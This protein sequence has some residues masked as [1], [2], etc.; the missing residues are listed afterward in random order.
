MIQLTVWSLPSLFA[1]GIS[2][3][4]LQSVWRQRQLPA[5]TMLCALL[6][7]IAWWSLGQ[8]AGTLVTDLE[9]K[10]VFAKIQYLAIPTVP[11]LWLLF[12]LHY[13]RLLPS[14]ARRWMWLLLVPCISFAMALTNSTH[15]LLW[16]G[17]T[18]VDVRGFIG[19]E[20]EYGPWFRVHTVYS[21]IAAGLG[22]MILFSSVLHSRWHVRRTIAMILAPVLVLAANFTYLV[23]NSPFAWLDLTPLGFALAGIPF[24]LALRD[25]ALDLVPLSREVVVQQLPEPVFALGMDGRILDLN[26]AAHRITQRPPEECIG[27]HL[28]DLVPLPSGFLTADAASEP[29]SDLVLSV[30]GTETAWRVRRAP[31]KDR[32][33]GPEGAIFIFHDQTDRT[34]VEQELRRTAA[35]LTQVNQQLERLTTIDPL[36]H[37]L[38]RR[39]L[40][41][42]LG[43]ELSRASVHARPLSI[44][45]VDLANLTQVNQSAGIEIADQVL[46]GIARIIESMRRESDATGRIGPGEFVILLPETALLEAR[47]IAAAIESALERGRFRASPGP[48]P[49]LEL[50]LSVTE[51]LGAR[52]TLDHVIDRAFQGLRGTHQTDNAGLR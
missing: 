43:A 18:L 49:T 24:T 19:W 5:A 6:A 1:T 4:L 10:F 12:S 30:G 3:W 26:P 52:D 35:E 38:N 15:G 28:R 39:E 33:Q 34:R 8:S 50:N 21:W 41:R 7:G 42:Q 25:H 20:P 29:T 14:L 40:M 2:L 36:T 31:L 16:T 37:V 13:T 23:P 51:S 46:T 9:L 17:G 48:D 47:R 11:V 27:K 44:I 22:T 32:G 45:L